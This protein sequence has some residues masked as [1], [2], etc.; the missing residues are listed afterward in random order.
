MAA[1]AGIDYDWAKTTGG[2]LSRSQSRALFPPLLRAVSRYPA[3]RLRLATGR[4]GTAQVDLDSFVLP[5][6][7]LVKETVEH[8]GEVLSPCMLAHS[9]RTFWFG[10]AI[11][12]HQQR[13]VDPELA[14][15]ATLMH[16]IAIE[17]PTP[18]RSFALVGAERTEEF[19]RGKGA[20]AAFAERVGAEICGHITVGALEDVT[21]PGGFVSAG[22]FVDVAGLGLE[23]MPAA[24]VDS[25]LERHPRQEW[26]KVL[27]PAWKAQAAAIPG[28]REPW[29]SRYAMIL[30][31]AR[32]A[33]FK[34]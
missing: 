16:D 25:V 33:P 20:D 29:L 2:V 27:R 12:A 32:I 26:K 21:S 23:Y 1:P 5:D 34:E 4:R 18:G 17:T 14:L 30:L 13:P 11:A 22:A 6:S 8:V 3:C 15:I 31:L 24:F 28:G 19:L 9:W 7:A 10:L